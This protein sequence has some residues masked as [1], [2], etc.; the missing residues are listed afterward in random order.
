MR[1][2]NEEYFQLDF[3]ARELEEVF[4][5][6]RNQQDYAHDQ[7]CLFFLFNLKAIGR[8]PIHLVLKW[9]VVTHQLL[10][11][12]LYP[13][14]IEDIYKSLEKVGEPTHETPFEH[15]LYHNLFKT[16]L[17]YLLKY[18][19][20]KLKRAIVEQIKTSQEGLFFMKVNLLKFGI[21]EFQ[22][23]FLEFGGFFYA[24]YPFLTQYH[25]LLEKDLKVVFSLLRRF[26]RI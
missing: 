20:Y 16:Y 19:I 15:Y 13:R 9:L 6:I 5:A 11:L 23:L 7:S 24:N 12:P 18:C 25:R 26:W 17:Q 14:L 10:R 1:I 2:D 8:K 3:K 21:N 4:S 22:D